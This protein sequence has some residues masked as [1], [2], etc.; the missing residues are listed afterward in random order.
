MFIS[1]I[2]NAVLYDAIINYLY[3]EY[4]LFLKQSIVHKLL[5]NL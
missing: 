2:S 5:Y 3:F 4:I 1:Y